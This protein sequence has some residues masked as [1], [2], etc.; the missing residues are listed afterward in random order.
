VFLAPSHSDL[1]ES[2]PTINLLGI[3]LRELGG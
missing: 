3:S 1:G 2:L